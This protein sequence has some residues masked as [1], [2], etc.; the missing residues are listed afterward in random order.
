MILSGH[1][2]G[3]PPWVTAI[4]QP[5]DAGWFGP[6][7]AAWQVNGSLATLVG[8]PRAL[9]DASLPSARTRRS[10]AALDVSRRPL[11]RLQRTNLYVTTSTFGTTQL[12]EQTAAMVNRF[13]N[14]CTAPRRTDAILGARPSTAAVGARRADR[15]DAACLP[16]LSAHDR[17]MPTHTSTTWRSW[18][19]ARGDRSAH[20]CRA[21]TA[22]IDSF[23]GRGQWRRV[24]TLGRPVPAL[25]R[26]RPPSAPGRRT[27]C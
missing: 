16:T 12:A 27:R 4:G 10:R 3:E 19:G 24:G 20:D 25:P 1:P 8:G 14:R 7:S 5:G 17:S 26:T 21:L 22:S 9:M 6:G 23:R 15:L 13:T 11:G 2:E 18:P